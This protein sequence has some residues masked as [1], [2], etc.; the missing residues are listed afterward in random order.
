MPK[1]CSKPKA[2]KGKKSLEPPEAPKG[3][4]YNIGMYLKHVLKT[5][6]QPGGHLKYKNM[7]IYTLCIKSGKK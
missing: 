1:T 7:V 3:L 4:A 5:K 2:S 6:A